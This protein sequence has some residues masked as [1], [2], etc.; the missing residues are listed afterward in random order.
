M[1][2]K[3]NMSKRPLP[4]PTPETEHFWAGTKVKE[5]RLQKCNSCSTIFFP[6]R[7]FCP[8][9][10]SREISVFL[11]SGK[12][13]LYSYVIS[14]LPA[15]GFNPPY[16]IAVAKLEEGPNMMCNI[17]DCEQSPEKLILDMPLIVKFEKINDEITLPQFTPAEKSGS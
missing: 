2:K 8:E 3:N 15:P 4:T 14:H 5:L 7:P 12:A 1:L 11:A 6:P 17:L 9:C 10:G 13:T 16:A